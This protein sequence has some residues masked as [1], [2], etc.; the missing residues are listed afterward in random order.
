MQDGMLGAL[1]ARLR[2]T[3]VDQGRGAG[4]GGA[5]GGDPDE[6]SFMQGVMRGMS[7]ATGQAPDLGPPQGP[8]TLGVGAPMGNTLGAGLQDDP[9][10]RMIDL[11]QAGSPL[12]PRPSPQAPPQ[13]LGP[14]PSEDYSMGLIDLLLRGRG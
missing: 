5:V 12:V 8:P 1:L 6:A 7:D 11:F 10:Q 9:R 14:V 13:Q 2:Q 3:Q 4:L